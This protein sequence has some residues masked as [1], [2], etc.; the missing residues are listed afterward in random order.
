MSHIAHR[1]ALPRR[2][3]LFAGLLV[4][5]L[6]I[7]LLAM[8]RQPAGL[9]ANPPTA[10][11]PV[12]HFLTLAHQGNIIHRTVVLAGPGEQLPGTSNAQGYLMANLRKGQVPAG[13][14]NAVVLSDANCEPDNDGISHCLNELQ[15]GAS[16]ITVQHHHNMQQ[17]PCL[18]PGETVNLMTLATYQS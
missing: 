17:V 4:G 7:G 16:I 13:A 11:A 18:T 14:T 6:L 8:V 15:I 10:P 5:A 1:S 12:P 9:A 3:L 2:L